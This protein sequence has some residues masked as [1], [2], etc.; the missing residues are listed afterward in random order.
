MENEQISSKT[1]NHL[2][3][4]SGMYDELGIGKVI[5][6]IIEQDFEQRHVSIG[7]ACKALVL[8][9]LGYTQKSLYLVPNY[10]KGKAIDLLIGDG[11][12]AE[13]L[14]ASTLGRALDD[15]YWYGTT[16]LY[17]SLVP[18]VIKALDLAP[19]FG[20]LDS[21]SFHLDGVYNSEHE[22]EEQAE[23]IHIKKGYSRDH[24]PE[25]NQVVLNLICDNAAGIPLHMEALSGNTSDK[26]SFENTIN[27]HVSEL[28]NIAPSLEYMIMDS[29]GYT[30]NNIRNNSEK[31]KWIS[32]VPEVLKQCQEVLLV[33]HKMIELDDNHSYIVLKQ[34]YGGVSQRWKLV[35]SKQAFK[36]EQKT[37]IKKY[38]E[39]S[40]DEYKG[41]LKLCK[42]SFSCPTDAEK[43]LLQFQKKCN[44]ISIQESSI[45]FIA[46]YST[47]GK[48]VKDSKPERYDYYIKGVVS[49]SMDKY[50]CLLSKK[51]KFIIATNELDE[52]KLKDEELLAAYKGQ[53]KVE[54]GFRFLKDPRF[55]AT[56]FFVKKPER[57]E[58]LLFI[59]TLCLTVYAALEYKLRTELELKNETIP[60][61]VGKPIKNPTMRW[62][63]QLFDNI[64]V[65]YGLQSPMILNFKDIHAKV[66]TLMGDSYRKYYF[67]L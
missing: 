1:L 11:I 5:D 44:Y 8:C 55:L 38:R 9:G 14:N 54:K 57:V 62:V 10:F 35:F 59:M 29:A 60:N 23:V 42:Q 49:C 63:F 48:P 67:R 18:S 40:L 50:D 58:A 25:L 3:L 34:E 56:S 33:D 7:Q 16:E 47:A 36:R 13:H 46:R 41:F 27:L 28:Q 26:T 2:G 51:G 6:S 15:V 22:L 37:L 4:V 21:T 19:R 45:C 43:A 65:L 64:Q 24:H 39:S 31:I 61:Q 66:L 32:R 17:S 52:T 30:K 12:E 20:Q 53:S